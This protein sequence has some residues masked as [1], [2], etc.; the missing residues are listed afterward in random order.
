MKQPDSAIEGLRRLLYGGRAPSVIVKEYEYSDRELYHNLWQRPSSPDDYLSHSEDIAY[1]W[2][3]HFSELPDTWPL[4]FYGLPPGQPEAFHPL[5][6]FYGSVIYCE[7]RMIAALAAR[8][9]EQLE[10]TLL[11]YELLNLQQGLISLLTECE[12]RLKH[13]ERPDGEGSLAERLEQYMARQLH[14]QLLML[15]QELDHRYRHLLEA[16]SVTLEEIY[17]KWLHRPVPQELPWYHT[18]TYYDF[19]LE[20][21][22]RGSGQLKDIEALLYQASADKKKFG[23]GTEADAVHDCIVRLQN[24]V[25][26]YVAAVETDQKEAYELLD[27]E[28]NRQQITD[29]IEMLEDQKKKEDSFR[30]HH[31]LRRMEYL[32]WILPDSGASSE[33]ARLMQAVRQIFDRSGKAPRVSAPPANDYSPTAVEKDAGHWAL[34]EYISMD[35]IRQKLNV[36]PNTLKRYLEESEASVI[37]F[38]Q[39]NKWMH[40]DDFH[41]FMKNHIEEK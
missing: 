18:K 15:L 32:L 33:A 19:Y 5:C 1:C 16:R 7:L 25:L 10:M 34:Q 22:L 40:Q 13:R 35:K 28:A 12:D 36:H 3:S 30:L 9:V 11:K 26:C 17:L 29:W 23:E 8:W 4:P 21:Y 31:L 39:K 2:Q 27:A 20:Q 41:D 14:R 6:K 38:S 37:I 24:I